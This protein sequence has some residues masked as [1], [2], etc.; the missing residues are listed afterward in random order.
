M[1]FKDRLIEYRKSLNIKTQTEMA[2]Q[3]DTNRQYYSNLESGYKEPS[4][5]ILKK[6]SEHSGKPEYYWKY[7]LEDK[8]FI[9]ERK[10]FKCL[11]GVIEELNE[12]DLLELDDKDRWTYEIESVLLT[13]LKA[14]ILH[15]Q[16]KRKN[17]K[18]ED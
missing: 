3:L 4:N 1:E 17:K 12:T 7:G 18:Q 13:A 5:I 16:L 2:K 6:L 9:D 10:E 8:D 15:M 14:D 11:Y